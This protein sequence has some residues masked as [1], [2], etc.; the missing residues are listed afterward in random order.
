VEWTRLRA[1]I[2]EAWRASGKSQKEVLGAVPFN[3]QA[4][5]HWTVGRNLPELENLAA[6]AEACG[7]KLV[8]ELVT[9]DTEKEMM[10]AASLVASLDRQARAIVL[11]LLRLAS[12]IDSVSW[13]TIS[14][15]LDG[16]QARAEQ[17]DAG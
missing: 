7:A 16:L 5:N 17:K 14:G 11:R 3:R 12:Y 1:Q 10:E 8:V 15:M 4:L 2:D 6:Y 13:S 9:E